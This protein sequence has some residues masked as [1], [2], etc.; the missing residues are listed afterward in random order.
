MPNFVYR[1]PEGFNKFVDTASPAAE[2]PGAPPPASP[3]PLNDEFTE[4]GPLDPAE[5]DVSGEVGDL[6]EP[7]EITQSDLGLNV[8]WTPTTAN[9]ALVL[10][11]GDAPVG[12]FALY[13]H[14]GINRIAGS[15]LVNRIG[16]FAAT[17]AGAKVTE[18]LFCAMQGGGAFVG[19]GGKIFTSTS[20][21]AGNFVEVTTL[22]SLW[23]RLRYTAVDRRMWA[24]FSADGRTWNERR[25]D[26][27]ANPANSVG[28]ACVS[29]NVPS[30][31]SARV[32][33]FRVQP[34]TVD[35]TSPLPS[36]IYE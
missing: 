17:M 10:R 8:A 12:D 15:A 14:I 5:W 4:V 3:D 18:G 32:R 20:Q 1:S 6:T 11:R 36:S 21:T 24:G 27:L 9:R 29:Q 23:L 13:A 16:L 26:V 33:S 7:L 19:V 25:K 35:P 34:G 30:L 31:L 2:F 28:L 22:S